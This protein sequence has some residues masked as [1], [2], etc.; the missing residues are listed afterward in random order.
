MPDVVSA[1]TPRPSRIY[2]YAIDF[3]GRVFHAGTEVDDPAVLRQLLGRVHR[4]AAGGCY[5]LCAGETN[6]LRP[7]DVLYVIAGFADA[8]VDGSPARLAVTCQG[9]LRRHLALETLRL[10][11]GAFLY[12]DVEGGFAARFG[13]QAWLDFALRHVDA[14]CAV[15]VARFG[16]ASWPIV[17]VP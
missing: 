8:P 4:D 6:E 16:A 5:S 2:R 14:T 15:F 1:E 17:V 9:G 11:A 12:G 10:R 13:R 3:E 7:D